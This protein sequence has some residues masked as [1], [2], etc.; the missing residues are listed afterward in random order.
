[1]ETTQLIHAEWQPAAAITVS[2][3]LCTH[4]YILPQTLSPRRA[5]RLVRLPE[6]KLFPL[7]VE[8]RPGHD[9]SV[10]T[11]HASD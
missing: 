5:G 9:K 1:M 11:G 7:W 6:K 3:T 2:I 10:Y 4:C 8:I